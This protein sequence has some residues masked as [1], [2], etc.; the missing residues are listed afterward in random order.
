M[1]NP[2]V[3]AFCPNS[4]AIRAPSVELTEVILVRAMDLHGCTLVRAMD[5]EEG[6][7]VREQTRFA[8]ILVAV[9]I[10]D[11]MMFCS[12]GPAIR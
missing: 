3:P 4:L 6:T 8:N 1:G 9:E 2:P 5:R 10:V 11:I 12:G 7:M